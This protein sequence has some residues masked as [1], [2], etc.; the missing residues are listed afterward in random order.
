M[1][2]KAVR[3]VIPMLTHLLPFFPL[4]LFPF[5]FSLSVGKRKKWKKGKK[6]SEKISAS[7]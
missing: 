6:K 3:W 1:A 5:V 2:T 7:K 4:F